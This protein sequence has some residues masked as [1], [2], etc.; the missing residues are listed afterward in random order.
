MEMPTK[1]FNGTLLLKLIRCAII[2][3]GVFHAK[4]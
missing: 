3:P 4:V 1:I 2:L